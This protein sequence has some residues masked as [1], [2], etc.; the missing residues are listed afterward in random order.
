MKNCV[1]NNNKTKKCLISRGKTAPEIICLIKTS[2]LYTN[3]AVLGGLF[4]FTQLLVC[5]VWF[6][7]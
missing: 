5:Y 6:E 2:S 1:V 3:L 4:A 7:S